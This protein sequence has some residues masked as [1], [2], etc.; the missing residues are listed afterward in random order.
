MILLHLKSST[1][2]QHERAEAHLNLMDPALDLPRYRQVLGTLRGL[3]GRLEPRIGAL[4]GESGRAALDWPARLKAPLLDRDLRALQVPAVG[5]APDR[6]AETAF[7]RSEPDAWGAAYVLEGATL[8]GQLVRRHLAAQLGLGEEGT[9]FYSSYGALTGPR[10]R[11][12][13][14][15][16]EARAA[17]DPEPALFT[18][19]VTHAARCTF[20]LFGQL[21]APGTP[22][23]RRPDDCAA[24]SG[25]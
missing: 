11:A 8:G 16:L 15:A 13:G 19:R 9:A 21:A 7:L 10:W 4:L 24:R 6:P 20:D 12:F 2:E 1:R 14:A 17:R 23:D 3:Y 25:L 22:P 18:D 5:S